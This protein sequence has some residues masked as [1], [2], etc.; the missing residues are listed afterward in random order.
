MSLINVNKPPHEQLASPD[1]HHYQEF[2][3]GRVE[4]YYFETNDVPLL[5]LRT[6]V[7]TTGGTKFTTRPREVYRHGSGALSNKLE[8]T[9][10][11][12]CT[13]V[14]T[15]LLQLQVLLDV[16]LCTVATTRTPY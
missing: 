11:N 14:C 6:S 3:W 8:L 15:L 16:L 7:I 12:S 9:T 10:S 4:F 5:R 13:Y 1:K 2:I